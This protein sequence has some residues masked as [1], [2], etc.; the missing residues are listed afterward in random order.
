MVITVDDTVTGKCAASYFSLIAELVNSLMARTH[1]VKRVNCHD[2][3][4]NGPTDSFVTQD[5]LLRLQDAFLPIHPDSAAGSSA[6]RAQHRKLSSLA[7]NKNTFTAAFGHRASFLLTYSAAVRGENTRK[8]ELS[9]LSLIEPDMEGS[10]GSRCRVLVITLGQ[11]KTNRFGNYNRTAIM[12]HKNVRLCAQGALALYFYCLFHCQNQPF[13]CLRSSREWFFRKVLQPLSS[14]RKSKAAKQQP[15]EDV[16]SDGEDLDEEET[17][18]IEMEDENGQIRRLP[19]PSGR[20]R[21]QDDSLMQVDEEKLQLNEQLEYLNAQPFCRPIGYPTQQRFYKAAFKKVGI[22][23]TKVT[24]FGCA[25][26]AST[27]SQ[28]GSHLDEAIRRHGHWNQDVMSNCYFKSF[29]EYC[30]KANTD[31]SHGRCSHSGR[32]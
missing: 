1:G 21:L 25:A 4:K 16:N 23:R 5:D 31:N 12:R 13:P 26:A 19:A 17:K 30:S 20:P 2:K 24:H 8:L 14:G 27:V 9:D 28:Y 18:F 10:E 6:E 22:V 7:N 11:G 32:L 3:A 15:V 29:R